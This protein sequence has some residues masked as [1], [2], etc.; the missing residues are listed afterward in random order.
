MLKKKK[1]PI[2]PGIKIPEFSGRLSLNLKYLRHIFELPMEFFS[3]R[4]NGEITS[5]FSDASKV[6]NA[7]ATI[8]ISLYLD[9]TIVILMGIVLAVQNTTL[10]LITLCSLPIYTIFNYLKDKLFDIQ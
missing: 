10:F 3:T 9:V 1:S 6:I 8:V 4:K 2:Y 5:R 7:L